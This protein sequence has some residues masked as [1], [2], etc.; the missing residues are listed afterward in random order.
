VANCSVASPNAF[1]TWDRVAE[2]LESLIIPSYEPEVISEDSLREAVEV[3]SKRFWEIF[4][5][6]PVQ[7]A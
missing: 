4:R 7:D 5:R 1:S 2:A 3:S 6:L